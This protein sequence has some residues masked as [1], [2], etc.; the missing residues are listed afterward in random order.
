MDDILCKQVSMSMSSSTQSL[1]LRLEQQNRKVLDSLRLNVAKVQELEK[2]KRKLQSAI[3]SI[4]DDLKRSA[5]TNEALE[6]LCKKA[7]ARQRAL[8]QDKQKPAPQKQPPHQSSKGY[9]GE[10]AFSEKRM[11]YQGF[12]KKAHGHGYERWERY[13]FVFVLLN[14]GRKCCRLIIGR[15]LR[16][17]GAGVNA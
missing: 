12:E 5:H 3:D 6:V 11:R 8:L 13:Y 4:I 17:R 10:R 16:V 1:V 15:L 9:P 7:L 2:D 14:E